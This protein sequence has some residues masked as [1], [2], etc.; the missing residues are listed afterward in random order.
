MAT[1]L[2]SADHTEVVTLLG[3]GFARAKESQ[4]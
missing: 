1:P 3:E 4:A 2:A